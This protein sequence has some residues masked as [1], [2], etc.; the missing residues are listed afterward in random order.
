M[1]QFKNCKKATV[2][3]I[4]DDLVSKGKIFMR[5]IGKSKVYCLTQDMTFEIDESIYTDEIDTK[6]DQTI[7]DKILRY[8]KWNYERHVAELIKLKEE[9][10]KLDQVLN[11]YE[12]QL[13][14]DE[15]KRA[16]EKMKAI[17]K[18]YKG[19]GKQECVSYEEFNKKKKVCLN[20][21]KELMKRT[22]IY[23]NII[24]TICEGCGIKKK[25]F[26]RDVGIEE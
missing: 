11:G 24:D 22:Q 2:Q 6:Q 14:I 15:L 13:S 5:T 9:C 12:N 4:L 18:E 25:D 1:L 16:I 19:K 10:K 20:I 26:L 17:V 7:D 23:K 3:K 8:L 21:K